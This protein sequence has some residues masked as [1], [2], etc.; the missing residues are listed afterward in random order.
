[1]WIPVDTRLHEHIKV[2][3][4]ASRL[5]L[6]HDLVVGLL[7]RLWGLCSD[8]DNWTLEGDAVEISQ[9]YR[10]PAGFLEQAAE[11]GFAKIGKEGVTMLRTDALNETA[12]RRR[13]RASNAA[14][15]RWDA[16]NAQHDAQSCSAD[17]RNAQSCSD[18]IE[19]MERGNRK[20]RGSGR[21]ASRP[22]PALEG[23][24]GLSAA[25][26]MREAMAS[27][28]AAPPAVRANPAEAI[29][30]LKEAS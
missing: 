25:A 21:R 14:R 26:A 18:A 30:A 28:G 12:E 6:P 27:I 9:H 13:E 16:R 8:F 22:P 10:L 2:Q 11:V 15:A 23:A 3:R 4:L 20:K 17:A 1:M 5:K 7:V 29:R 24:G 19:G